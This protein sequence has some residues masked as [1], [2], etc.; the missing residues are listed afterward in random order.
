M[1]KTYQAS[2]WLG[3]PEG[4]KPS[5]RET[6]D[7]AG[8][9]L[10][11][12]HAGFTGHDTFPEPFLKNGRYSI[13]GGTALTIRYDP[14]PQRPAFG[15]RVEPDGERLH[16][17]S[18][19]VEAVLA[20]INGGVRA[21]VAMYHLH[22]APAIH[23]LNPPVRRSA[24]VQKLVRRFGAYEAAVLS[25]KP[26]LVETTDVDRLC[27]FL[28]APDRLLPVVVISRDNDF[29]RLPTHPG[30][31]AA[32]L[33]GLAHVFVLESKLASIRLTE[34]LGQELGCYHGMVR[35]YW[36][37]VVPGVGTRH[38]YWPRQKVRELA[39]KFPETILRIIAGAASLR[40]PESE[41]R[42][43]EVERRALVHSAPTADTS[44][45]ALRRQLAQTSD[46]L[47]LVEQKAGWWERQYERLLN[48]VREEACD[49][50][51]L[52]H[53]NDETVEGAFDWALS[54]Y[55]NRLVLAL[56]SASTMK[57]SRYEDGEGVR[58]ALRTLATAYYDARMGRRPG[59]DLRNL[60]LREAGFTYMGKQ[61]EVTIGQYSAQYET[62]WMGKVIQLHEHIGKGT[63]HDPRHTIRIAFHFDREHEVIVIG[64]VGQHQRTRAT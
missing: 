13:G 35:I 25:P 48:R 36:P 30:R 39:D 24:L 27:E 6:I 32:D 64:Y 34:V 19:A 20:Q 63:A 1:R 31:I 60:F 8:S 44:V 2:F 38:R 54:R 26:H 14:S 16:R 57:G 58:K 50:G 41:L 7:V 11:E 62:T 17:P 51:P 52:P 10:F 15:M 12:D 46:E 5:L 22:G 45:E 18:M 33:T 61:S 42:W 49:V 55:P 4:W 59:G 23:P 53:E 9:W 40:L 28:L 21:V 29:N 3:E 56:N 37:G 43:S 47:G